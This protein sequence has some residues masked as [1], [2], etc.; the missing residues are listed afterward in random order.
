MLV[1]IPNDVLKAVVT[2]TSPARRSSR[3][4]ADGA[5]PR[6]SDAAVRD[7]VARIRSAR[8]PVAIIG[9]GVRAGAV[10]LYRMFVAMLGLPHA[11]TINALGAAAPGD[12]SYLGMLGMHGLKAANKAVQ[13]ADLIV[14]LGM[15]FDDRVTGKPDRFAREATVIHA[16]IDATE[17]GKIIARRRRRCTAICATRCAR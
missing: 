1:D 17:F 6:A 8:R 14:A 4:R 5:G 2:Q 12:P 15:R 3:S 13:R 10:D 16:D 7:A 9:G 11:A